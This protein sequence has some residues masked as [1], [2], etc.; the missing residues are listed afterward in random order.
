MTKACYFLLTAALLGG[1]LRAEAQAPAAPQPVQTINLGT[2]TA[3]G[4][5]VQLANG[6][7]VLLLND[8]ESNNVHV[9]CLGTDGQ[10]AWETNVVREQTPA[11]PKLD[12]AIFGALSIS[13]SRSNRDAEAEEKARA[14]VSL[15]PVEV[16]TCGNDIYVVERIRPN[17]A[18]KSGAGNYKPNQL[19]VQH[20]TEAGAVTRAVFEPLPELPKRIEENVMGCYAE[21]NEY[22][23]VVR[24]DNARE[25]TTVYYLDRY[26]LSARTH[27]REAFVLPPAP[28]Q[29]KNLGSFRLFFQAWA[30]LGHRPGQTYFCR[31]TVAESADKNAGKRLAYE[32]LVADGKGA[33]TGGFTTTLNLNA[34]TGPR[35]SG[36]MPALGDIDHIP[37]YYQERSGNV[38]YWRDA[39]NTS[40]GNI[41]TF[42]LE[43]AT[44]NVVIFGE[45]G[46]GSAPD[47][48][49]RPDLLGCFLRR[50]APDGSVLGAS[51]TTYGPGMREKCAEAAFVGHYFRQCRFVPDPM[52][53]T[54]SF[55]FDGVNLGAKPLGTFHLFFDPTLKYERFTFEAPAKAGTARPTNLLYLQPSWRY[56]NGDQRI[57]RSYAQP[58]K[59]ENPLYATLAQLRRA[60]A[61]APMH[62]FYLGA[63]TAGSV[64]VVERKQLVGGTLAVYKL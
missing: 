60:A 11:K 47:P 13:L 35:H 24:T 43:P 49:Y 59:A 16:L 54:Y 19:I 4:G 50:Y 39:W 21:G 30:Y 23:Q 2:H 45:Y 36:N 29:S 28:T 6:R 8:T 5:A 25:E 42:Y 15:A 33:A 62:Q 34:D 22:V 12:D 61:T 40:T 14:Q 51:Q 37:Q 10:T 7:T 26:D 53:N 17:V 31:R 20:L 56:N 52:T 32:V 58:D 48:S 3:L 55:G 9:Q 27:R 1:T 38:V 18:K 64:V 44:G 41:G 46:Q 63:P 57:E